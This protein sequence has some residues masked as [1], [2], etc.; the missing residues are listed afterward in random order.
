MY[1]DDKDEKLN[2]VFG[3]YVGDGPSPQTGA[4]GRAKAFMEKKA[5]RRTVAVPVAEPVAAGKGT[6]SGL[7]VSGKAKI[8]FLAAAFLL[9]LV[10]L[11]FIFRPF[12]PAGPAPLSQPCY[13][14]REQL[15]ETDAEYERKDFLPFV[16]KD[17][18]NVYREFSLKDDVSYHAGRNIVVYYVEYFS[19]TLPVRLYVEPE[20]TF[21]QGLEKYK[22]LPAFGRFGG[23]DFSAELGAGSSLVYFSRN[24]YGYN[25]EVFTSDRAAVET[26]LEDIGSRL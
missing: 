13:L 17:R 8:A 22:S 6:R 9:L 7:P 15:T 16:E 3:N 4:T 10:A 19:G 14:L 12:S 25:L 23:T 1:T 2:E 26:L 18:V 24:G 20:G 11:V 5:V 21:L